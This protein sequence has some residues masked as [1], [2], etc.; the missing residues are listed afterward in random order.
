[1][2]PK[3]LVLD[4]PFTGLDWLATERILGWLR[5]LSSAGHTIVV[6]THN[7]RAVAEFAERALLLSDG[8]CLAVESPRVVGEERARLAETGLARPQA[9]ELAHR[10]SAQLMSAQSMGPYGLC[11][12]SLDVAELTEDYLGALRRAAISTSSARPAD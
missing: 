11:R 9:A 7:M 2:R 10:L 8:Q 4:E 12:L 3:V 1:M 6:I 5:D